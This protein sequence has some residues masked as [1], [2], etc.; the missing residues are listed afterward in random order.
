VVV[1][2]DSG[3]FPLRKKYFRLE[4]TLNRGDVLLLPLE[5]DYYSR[6]P[7]LADNFLEKVAG[8]HLIVEH[9][10][11]DLPLL[12]K[13]RFILREYPVRYVF[14]ALFVQRNPDPQNKWALTRLQQFED[15]FR[16]GGSS[17]FGAQER[18]GP[19]KINFL[20]AWSGGCDRY[21][22]WRQEQ[23]LLEVSD[24]FRDNLQLFRRLQARG[25]RIHFL[26]PAV[27]DSERSD[28][29]SDAELIRRVDAYAAEIRRAVEA[30]GM[31]FLGNYSDSHF[32]REC[33]LNTYY[34]LRYSCARDRTSRLLEL[35]QAREPLSPVRGMDNAGFSAVVMARIAALRKELANQP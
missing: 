11:S 22:F 19:E 18:D 32:P 31:S 33:F 35:L 24:T 20:A 14:E 8:P 9:Y 25:V 17:A 16:Q 27:V 1:V 13:L 21:L 5:W 2:S 7:Q 4:R 12:E 23:F 3:S 10:F 30:A 26:W 6:P 15:R 34:H 29:Y 28:C